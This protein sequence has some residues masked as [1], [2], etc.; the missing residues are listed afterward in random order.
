MTIQRGSRVTVTTLTETLRI[1]R[2]WRWFRWRYDMQVIPAGTVTRGRVIRATS[3]DFTVRV[4]LG[5]VTFAR[6]DRALRVVV[7]S[8]EGRTARPCAALRGRGR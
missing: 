1:T 7:R 4:G 3:G 2:R 5:E 8:D 6:G